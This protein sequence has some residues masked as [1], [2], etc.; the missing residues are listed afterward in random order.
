MTNG[1][2]SQDATGQRVSLAMDAECDAAQWQAL[3][4]A[5]RDDVH[6]RQTWHAYQLI[7]DV[8]RSEDLA[9]PAG[10][11]ESF[12][13]GLRTR[14]AAE[15]VVLAP[16]ASAV[17]AAA[18]PAGGSRWRAYTAPMAVTAGFLAVAAAL[19][20]TQAPDRAADSTM[21]DAAPAATVSLAQTPTPR[22]D[23]PVRPVS[24]APGTTADADN[25]AAPIVLIRDPRLEQY[26]AA[27]Q[28]FAGSTALGVP[29]G[30]LRSATVDMP[31]R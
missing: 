6:T 15:P 24:T 10:H 28:Q 22:V 29:S 8:L 30:F 23:S 25:A 18:V 13:R 21:V 11:D 16:P 12:L 20:V 4:T 1:P 31:Q 5:W 7:G 27:H 17:P 14:L 3:T 9:T 2:E 19:L 26:L